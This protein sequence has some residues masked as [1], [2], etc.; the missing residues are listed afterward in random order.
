MKLRVFNGSNKEIKEEVFLCLRETT[1]DTVSLSVVNEN[2]DHLRSPNIMSFYMNSS[3]K[4][5]FRRSFSVNSDVV[6]IDHK[7]KITEL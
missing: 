1:G 7:G 6:E 3:G 4:L 2:G 5:Q